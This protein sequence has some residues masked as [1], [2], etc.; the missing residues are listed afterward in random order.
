[1]TFHEPAQRRRF[2]SLLWDLIDATD[3]TNRAR[4]PRK[5]KLAYAQW[6]MLKVLF[7]QTD[8]DTPRA[9]VTMSANRSLTQKTVSNWLESGSN[10]NGSNTSKTKTDAWVTEETEQEESKR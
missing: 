9:T 6:S 8:A 5:H 7:E 2:R 4:S 3:V 1:M 10:R